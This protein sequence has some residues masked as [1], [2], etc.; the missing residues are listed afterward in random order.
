MYFGATGIRYNV[1]RV[2]M[3]SCDFSL[4]SYSFDDNFGIPDKKLKNFDVKAAVDVRN[5]AIPTSEGKAFISDHFRSREICSTGRDSGAVPPS[6][7][8]SSDGIHCGTFLPF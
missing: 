4:T 5:G 2:P 1:G 8:F 7:L 3:N 6:P